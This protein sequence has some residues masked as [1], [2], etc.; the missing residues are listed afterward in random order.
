MHPNRGKPA[1]LLMRVPVF[2]ML[3]MMSLRAPAQGPLTWGRLPPLPNPVG[4]AGAYAGVA[5]GA[6]LVAGGANFPDNVGPWGATKK[7]WYDDVF[8]LEK[9]EGSWKKVGRLPRPMGYGVAL[10]VPGGVLCLGG[11]DARWHYPSA[12][13]LTYENGQ[14][15]TKPLAPL[16]LPLANACGAVLGNTVYVA[17]GIESPGDTIAG[18]WFLSLDLTTAGA[19]WQ[20]LPTWPWPERRTGSFSCFRERKSPL[21]APRGESNAT[22]CATR[23]PSTR[24]KAP[25]N[26]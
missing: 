9:P 18:K 19:T 24:R 6:L 25:G 1:P 21:M 15:S 16:P 8:V 14:L 23:T 11:A 10:T 7:T 3:L 22:I 12:F 26:A 2:F 13:L 4:F 20:R 17:G 5:H